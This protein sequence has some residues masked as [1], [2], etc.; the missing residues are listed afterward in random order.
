[1]KWDYFKDIKDDHNEK[2]QPDLKALPLEFTSAEDYVSELIGRDFRTFE[3]SDLF[4]YSLKFP[5]RLLI[6]F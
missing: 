1:M 3:P 2:D 4:A 5:T 6:T